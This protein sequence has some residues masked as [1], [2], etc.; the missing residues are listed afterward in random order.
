MK[1]ICVLESLKAPFV[2][3]RDLDMSASD[4]SSDNPGN[5]CTR[6]HHQDTLK[7]IARQSLQWK[8]QNVSW[9]S[10][11]P[12]NDHINSGVLSFF[13]RKSLC[14]PKDLQFEEQSATPVQIPAQISR[15]KGE[16]GC[17]K[18]QCIKDSS[19]RH[20]SRFRWTLFS[21]ETEDNW[22]STMTDHNKTTHNEGHKTDIV[23]LDK[24]S[25]SILSHK[26]PKGSSKTTVTALYNELP[27]RNRG[28]QNWMTIC[29]YS[30][31]CNASVY[32]AKCVTPNMTT[33]LFILFSF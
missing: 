8:Q 2:D 13:T 1:C 6:L 21:G 14:Q 20:L 19:M 10:P 22:E 11:A 18:L 4:I 27:Q 25:K 32:T 23:T 5:F 29:V 24:R 15:E 28:D 30:L 12:S 9:K 33:G 7:V 17:L 31:I 3:L 16:Y 26:T